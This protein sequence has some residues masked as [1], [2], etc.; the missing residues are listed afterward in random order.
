[1]RP[2][3]ILILASLMVA[4]CGSAPP[5]KTDAELRRER[6]IEQN[7][8]GRRA[9]SRGDLKR[10]AVYYGE[11]LRLAEEMEDFHGV[12]VNALNLAAVLQA[13]GEVE[14]ARHVLEKISGAPGRFESRFIADAAGRQAQLAL[15]EGKLDLAEQ[16]LAKAESACQPPACVSRTALLNLRGQLH[17]AHGSAGE[18][19]AT[20]AQALAASRAEGNRDEEANALRLDGRAATRSGDYAAAAVRLEG[21]LEIDRSLASPQKIAQDLLA[22]AEVE[23]GRGNGSAARDYAQ[24]AFDVSRAS[25]NWPQQAEAARLL[26]RAK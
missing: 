15:Q 18:A 17:L 19:R 7:D 21:A 8:N 12:A 13:L 11:A 26:E 10:A 16:W 5:P 4:G 1:M 22:L 23:F 24:R 2:V 9:A 6:Q 20:A 14:P 3:S 25:G